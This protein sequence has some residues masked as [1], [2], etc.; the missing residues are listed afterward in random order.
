MADVIDFSYYKE[1]G[2]LKTPDQVDELEESSLKDLEELAQAMGLATDELFVELMTRVEHGQSL[3]D[4]PTDVLIVE[5]MNR[6]G[7][8]ELLCHKAVEM[9]N[10]SE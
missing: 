3:R 9:I 8:M 4:I 7:F 6:V 1:T 10:N 2:E 5:M